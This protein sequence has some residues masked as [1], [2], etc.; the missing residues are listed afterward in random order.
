MTD[1]PEP[2]GEPTAS[3]SA[4]ADRLEADRPLPAGFRGA[5]GR[6]LADLDPGY[7][8]RPPRLRLIATGYLGAGALLLA[9]GLLQAT[10]AL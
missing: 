6:R 3:E 4:L 8:P 1:T 9:T 10:G 5:L 2:G 7:G